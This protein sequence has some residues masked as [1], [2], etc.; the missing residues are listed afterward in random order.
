MAARTCSTSFVRWYKKSGHFNLGFPTSAIFKIISK[1][2]CI[3]C[4]L[5]IL[6]NRMA[7]AGNNVP[8]KEN[9]QLSPYS[10]PLITQCEMENKATLD[11]FKMGFIHLLNTKI[12]CKSRQITKPR[13]PFKQRLYCNS[14]S[15]CCN[16]DCLLVRP[17]T[18]TR[19]KPGEKKLPRLQSQKVV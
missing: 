10:F 3:L 6:N 14:L 16:Y 13:V 1:C 7:E 5:S 11:P 9:N 18:N 19:E 12:S 17:T 4:C 8:S 15:V 2:L